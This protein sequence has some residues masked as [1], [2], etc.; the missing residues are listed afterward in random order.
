MRAIAILLF[1]GCALQAD[2]WRPIVV[3]IKRQYVIRNEGHS[4]TPVY[5][6][7]EYPIECDLIIDGDSANVI[8]QVSSMPYGDSTMVVLYESAE[9]YEQQVTI[10]VWKRKYQVKYERV[11]D[12]TDLIQRF[13]CIDSKLELNSLDLANRKEIRG[14][15]EFQGKCVEGCSDKNK[16]IRIAGN[17]VFT[18]YRF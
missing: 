12:F 5:S 1:L 3:N 4:F 18:V 8:R 16:R 2:H 6:P 13:E 7:N 10:Y 17:F 15:L 14:Y 11:I 9:S